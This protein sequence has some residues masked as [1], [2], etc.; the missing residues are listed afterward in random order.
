VILRPDT[1][2]TLAI[3]QPAHA[4]LS[5]RLAE[6]W[7]WQFAPLEAVRLAALQHDIG[8][9]AWDSA[10]ELDPRSG[11]PYSFTSMPRAMHV[12]LWSGAA[13]LVVSQSGYAALLV[14]MH[15]TGLYQRYVSEQERSQEPARSY[16]DAEQA[17]QHDLAERLG[18]DPDQLR[19][20]A[21][22]LACWDWM[23]LFACT[24]SSERTT[25]EGVPG[26]ADGRLQLAWRDRAAGLIGIEPWPFAEPALSL[27]V[28][29]R[30]LSGSFDDQAQLHAALAAAP[31]VRV[32]LTATA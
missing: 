5:G 20:N 28:E 24:A 26:A 8:M 22:L 27:S 13:R 32:G 31:L 18:A 21:A 12:E 11:L 17:F 30:L 3:G 6:A 7:G 15:G 16:L 19:R 10:P 4:W 1:R 2:G 25:V 23:S 9:A 14:S 29:G